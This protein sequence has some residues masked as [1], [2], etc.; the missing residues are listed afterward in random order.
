MI[1]TTF[2]LTDV[3]LMTFYG[4]NNIH[5]QLFK[6]FYPKLRIVARDN[7]VKIMGDEEEIAKATEH[8]ECIRKHIE[9]YN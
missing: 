5:L 3:D 4:M 7:V 8:L 2:L 1:E 6:S 9:K